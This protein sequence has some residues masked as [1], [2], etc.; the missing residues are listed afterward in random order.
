MYERLL[1][2]RRDSEINA[3]WAKGLCIPGFDPA[4]WRRDTFGSLMKRSE[5]GNCCEYGWEIDHIRPT[6]MLGADTLFNKQP[7]NWKN[8]RKKSDNT[9]SGMLGGII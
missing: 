6:S 2:L 9:I 7:L 5:Y 8:N 3:V 1:A 4:V